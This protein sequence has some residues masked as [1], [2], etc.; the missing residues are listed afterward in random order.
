MNHQLLALARDVAEAV[1]EESAQ[2][3]VLAGGEL[4]SHG[5]SHLVDRT[6]A[7]DEPAAAI[8]PGDGLVRRWIELVEKVAHDLA[9]EI[10]HR[11]DSLHAAVLVDDDSEGLASLPHLGEQL[12]H[13]A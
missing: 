4:Q 13:V 10:L 11:E 1:E 8:D 7:V 2:G 3:D 5:R 9:D 12:E 6:A